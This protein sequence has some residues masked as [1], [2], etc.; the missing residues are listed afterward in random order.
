VL[1]IDDQ[2]RT[3]SVVQHEYVH[4][5]VDVAWPEAPLWFNEGLAEYLSTFGTDGGRARAGA[6]V[7]AHVAWLQLHDLLPLHQLFAIGQASPDYHEGDRRG[8]FYAESWALMDLMFSGSGDDVARLGRV[9]VACREGARFET[10]FAREFGSEQA[11]SER[12]HAHLEQGRWPE[13]TWELP[14]AAAPPPRVSARVPPADVLGSLALEL[15]SR[16]V[17]Q[18]EDAEAHVRQALALD[19]R[20]PD[21]LAGMGWLELMRGRRAEARTWFDRAIATAPLSVTAVR[22]LASQLLLDVSRSQA[23][24]EREAVTTYVRSA[25]ERALATSPDD[26]E[27]LALLARSWAVWYADDPEPGYAPAVRAAAALPGRSD[28]LLDQLA[29]TSLTGRDTEARRIYDAHFRDGAT[30]AERHAARNALL[31]GAVLR[32][33]R[34]AR[35]GDAATAEAR[36]EAARPL[37][38]DDPELVRELESVLDSLHAATRRSERTDQENRAIAEYNRGVVAGNAHRYS[39]AQAAFKRAAS[40][41][42]RPEFQRQALRLATR[43]RQ[44]QDGERAFALAR[45]G[46]V[47]EAIA[48]FEAM[49]RASMSAED[50][51]WRDTNLAHL[52]ARRR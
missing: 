47:G 3:P 18:R 13:R 49:D 28:V 32:A 4:S 23:L 22:V 10:V 2:G 24:A 27:L 50:Q 9:L 15:L 12:L 30:E 11:L 25:V 39:E 48:I 46:Q 33:G 51:Q 26:P 41:S 45:A 20:A 16:P 42:A 43:M 5:L 38:A 40:I 52:R 37:I 1:C 7:A 6:P 29:L 36:L 14:A 19:A 21:A 8:T 34:S 35:A 44:Q 31:A 17:A